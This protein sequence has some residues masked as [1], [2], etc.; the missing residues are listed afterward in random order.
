MK[1]EVVVVLTSAGQHSMVGGYC[2]SP[3]A[4]RLAR[5]QLAFPCGDLS[6]LPFHGEEP[7]IG[8]VTRGDGLRLC[9]ASSDLRNNGIRGS[10]CGAAFRAATPLD[11]LIQIQVCAKR[12][13]GRAPRQKRRPSVE[14]VARSGDRA[15]TA[16]HSPRFAKKLECE[17]VRYGGAGMKMKVVIHPA[18][19]LALRDGNVESRDDRADR[20]TG[21]RRLFE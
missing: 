15:T 4:C 3:L 6:F 11:I 12:S 9:R 14:L 5:H 20:K 2:N 17:Q 18:G 21:Q 8:S 1:A 10:P 16:V 19:G 13:R 7:N